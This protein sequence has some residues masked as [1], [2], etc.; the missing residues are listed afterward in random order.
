M[1]A[2]LG[3]RAEIPCEE[4]SR[5]PSAH[6]EPLL[7]FP[8]RDV[9]TVALRQ[10]FAD[11]LHCVAYNGA[12][13]ARPLVDVTVSSATRPPLRYFGFQQS[14]Q[15]RIFLPLTERASERGGTVGKATQE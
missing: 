10:P 8:G 5:S 14:S 4:S 7:L 3:R 9:Q 12:F 11:C 6:L 1:L 13:A 2:L 15:V